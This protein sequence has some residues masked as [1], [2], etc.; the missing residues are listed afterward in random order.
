MNKNTSPAELLLKLLDRS[1]CAV[2]VAACL[3]D[4]HSIHA[5]GWNSEGP[6][7]FGLHA[8][9]A[10][11]MRANPKRIKGSR[12]Y[13][14]ARRKKSGNPVIARPCADCWPSCRQVQTIY[15]RDKHGVWQREYPN[16]R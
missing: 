13:V 10:C 11:F 9:R 12:L 5:W 1:G 6:D 14:M 3:A 2:Q 15:W 7:G 4:N 16:S 8:E